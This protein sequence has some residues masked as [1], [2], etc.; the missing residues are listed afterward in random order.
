MRQLF[1]RLRK[2]LEGFVEQLDDLL[3]LAACGENDTAI[4]LKVLRDLDRASSA[5]LFLLFADDFA[6]AESFVATAIQR[7]QEE[8]RLACEGR[9][10]AGDEPWPPLPSALFDASRPPADPARPAAHC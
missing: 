4:A 7:F 1:Q 3:L 2:D 10:Q 8:H 6:D 9:A 5:D